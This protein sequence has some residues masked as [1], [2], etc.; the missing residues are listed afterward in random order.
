MVLGLLLLAGRLQRQPDVDGSHQIGTNS[1]GQEIGPLVVFGLELMK[2]DSSMHGGNV[3]E[4]RRTMP[5]Q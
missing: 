3:K 4:L 2:V 1:Q 5:S